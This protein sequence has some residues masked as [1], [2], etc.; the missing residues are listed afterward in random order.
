[1]GSHIDGFDTMVNL[2]D[3]SEIAIFEG[4][5]YLSSAIDRRPKF[6]LYKAD[7]A[8]I[9]GISWD[10]INV[11]PS[12]DIYL[13]QFRIF[14]DTICKKGKLVYFSDDPL[15]NDIAEGARNDI[16]L[17]PYSVHGF[18]QNKKGFFA[19]T[20]NRVQ[21]MEI[22]GE[23]NMQNL[24]AALKVCNELGI[25]DDDFY[26]AIGKF[27]GSG[28][29]MQQISNSDSCAVYLDFAHAPSKVKATVNA[30]ADRYPHH[31]LIACLELHTYSSLNTEFINN[32]KGSLDEADKA[33]VYYNP[34][35]LKIKNLPE[36]DKEQVKQSFG[37]DS[38]IVSN[39]SDELFNKINEEA[40]PDT[41]YLFM[42]SGDF[43]GF[44]LDSFAK[45]LTEY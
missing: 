5:E 9:N 43:N 23:H 32:Y 10:H 22:F 42:S 31:H 35:A 44:N 11:F 21:K 16:T 27:K 14:A 24:S 7:I 29:R 3:N 20:H 8:V 36:L 1:V 12:F 41:V 15:V 45:G 30:L 37:N 13:E 40:G 25:N 39:N 18:F 19:A 34:H 38:I 4:D 6:H 2:S 17:I 33:Y 26:R 28:K